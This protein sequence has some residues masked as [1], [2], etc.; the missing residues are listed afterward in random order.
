MYIFLIFI[1][2][3]SFINFYFIYVYKQ[4]KLEFIRFPPLKK[5]RL[6]MIKSCIFG[7]TGQDGS[8]LAEKL[9]EK[10]Y[11]VYGVVRR[12]SSFNRARIE[13]IR[14]KLNLHYGDV[15][16][17]ISVNKI[18]N[19][20][21]PD[22]VYNFSA[23]SHVGISFS[24]PLY[25]A[26]TNGL[27]SLNILESIL[28]HSPKTKYIQASTSELYGKVLEIPQTEKTQFNPVNPYAC[29]KL[30]G[31]F[32]TKI[33]RESYNIFACNSICFNHESPRRGENFVTKKITLGL[34]NWLKTGEPIR[35]GN[36]EAKRDFG[37]APEFCDCL[38]KII[39]HSKPDDFV[40]ATGENHSIREFI[41]EASKY[42]NADIEWI[43]S[44]IEEKG[45]DKNTGKIII[46]IDPIYFRPSEVDLLLGDY[47]K[48]KNILGWEP[49]V[50]FKELVKIMMEYDLKNQKI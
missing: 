39:E 9:L 13:H 49:K 40:I 43:G 20:I 7:V 31:Y 14:T 18:I 35:L 4:L 41:E 44:G 10:G 3:N 19:E 33:Y 16:D 23:Q 47:T 15:T 11:D 27:G 29:A 32:I 2:F 28:N 30:Y 12:S 45:I 38:I 1:D 24:N 21:K 48:A 34:V 6:F 26:N 50:K 37:Y 42:I 25:T 22:Y 46:E 5:I 17:A 36:L 8:Y